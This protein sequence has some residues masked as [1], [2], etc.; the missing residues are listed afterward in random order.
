MIKLIKSHALILF[1]VLFTV[2]GQ[3]IVKWQMVKL[4]PLPLSLSEKIIV[5]IKQIYNPWIL[6]V[7]FSAFLAA[8]CWMAAMTKFDISYAYPYISL[9]FVLVLLFSGIFFHETITIPRVVGMTLIVL[10]ILVGSQG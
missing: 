7:F 2:Y 6:S 10:G 5:I 3:I 1:T 4:A 8:L 9:S